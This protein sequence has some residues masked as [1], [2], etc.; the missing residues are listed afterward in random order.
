MK[1]K[2]NNRS[3][4]INLMYNKGGICTQWTK[5]NNLVSN[6]ECVGTIWKKKAEVHLSFIMFYTKMNSTEG[7]NTKP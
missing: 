4:Y 7:T 2:I 5:I 1:K 6:L 3:K